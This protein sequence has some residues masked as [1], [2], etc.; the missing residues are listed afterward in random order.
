MLLFLYI[1]MAGDSEEDQSLVSNLLAK[2]KFLSF[3]PMVREE[4]GHRLSSAEETFTLG[5]KQSI[6]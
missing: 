6:S 3:L 5:W 4:R 1:P 2:I